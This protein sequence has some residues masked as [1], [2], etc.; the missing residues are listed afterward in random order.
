VEEEEASLKLAYSACP[1]M[2]PERKRYP[3]SK[4]WEVDQMISIGT[5]HELEVRAV[6]TPMRAL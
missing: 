1:L 5:I 4:R 2:R 3:C 6:E